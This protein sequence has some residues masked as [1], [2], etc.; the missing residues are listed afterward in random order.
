MQA[1]VAGNAGLARAVDKALSSDAG[2]DAFNW[3]K[4]GVGPIMRSMGGMI[5][6]YFAAGGYASGTDTIP[7]MLTPGE[8]VMTK[9][10]VD[11][12]GAERLGSINEGTYNGESVYNYNL[13]VNVSGANL[14]ADDVARS[15]MT[16]IKQINSQQLRGNKF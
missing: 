16:Q 9:Y 11:N 8:F 13:S 2:I 12:F 10:A 14:N 1:R 15:V 3:A 7:A 4:I 5:P 6:S